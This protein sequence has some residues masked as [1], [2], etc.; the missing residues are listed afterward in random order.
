MITREEAKE[1]LPIM[2]AFAEG[3]QIQDKIDGLTGWVDTDEINLEY[4]GKKIQHRIKPEPKY[5]P[6]NTQEECWNEMLKH[7]PIGYI[8]R[9]ELKNVVFVTEISTNIH[10]E[11][12]FG[13]SFSTSVYDAG[14]LFDY[15]TFVD[16]SPF[17][18]K[19]E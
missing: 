12:S 11:I 9:K 6:F 15:Y 14:C 5:R 18:I 17:G 2:K 1:L 8:E 19:E 7:Q 3:K 13:L 4:E 10:N 16:G